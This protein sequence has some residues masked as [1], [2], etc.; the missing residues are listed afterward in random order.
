MS[1]LER[2]ILEQMDPRQIDVFGRLG[3]TPHA[4]QLEF[5]NATEDEVLFGGSRGGGKTRSLVMEG[6]KLSIHHPG[7]R[8]LIIRQSFPQLRSTIVAE[9][10]KIGFARRAFGAQW[11]D[12]TMT[13]RFPNGSTLQCGYVSALTDLSQYQGT[14]HDALLI[15]ELSLLIP[16]ALPILRET[17]RGHN[18][19]GVR[20]TTNPGGP[21]HSA[22]KAEFVDAT[23]KGRI[24]ATADDG[25]TRRY[26][27][28]TVYDNLANVGVNYL[29][30]LEG[31]ADPAR[32]KAML[33]GDFDAFGGQV[34]SEW[35]ARR[36]VVPPIPKGL[37]LS[38][39]RWSGIDYG[40]AAPFSY[41][42]FALDNDGRAWLEYEIY[43]K[44]LSPA[45]QAERIMEC[46][47]IANLF[48]VRHVIDP[49]TSA[50]VYAGGL[51]IQGMYSVAGLTTI[52]G[53][54]DRLAGWQTIHKYL[55]EGPLCLYHRAV[56]NQGNW[57]S[58]TCPM[59]HVI[60]GAAPNF[61]RELAGAPYDPHKV[62]DV[63]TK[64]SDHA[65]DAGRYA[66]HYIGSAFRFF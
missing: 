66:L 19:I 23:E 48:E 56:K 2:M 8:S 50:Q 53:N 32:R 6:L 28:S 54:N 10:A 12:S 41:E 20:A 47:E 34:F 29:A 62:E 33:E 1:D 46:E 51:S 14:E 39:M 44:G 15:D 21:S 59:L 57:P 61:V 52:P 49:A 37:P 31:I 55:A 63:D 13:L 25:R 27:P 36:H 38:W 7:M 22:V 35:N 43:E 16:E 45:Q 64:A 58:E 9:L 3:Y 5:H 40:F 24:V 30:I 65:I 26:I 17:L 42:R 18:V 60:D 11:N 4:R